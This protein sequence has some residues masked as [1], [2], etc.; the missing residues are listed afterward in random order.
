MALAEVR[1]PGCGVLDI[2]DATV[3]YSGSTDNNSINQRSTTEILLG[4]LRTAWKENKNFTPINR[5]MMKMRLKIGKIWL[6][7]I[8]VYAPTDVTDPS[9]SEEFYHQLSH[10]LK[11][12]NNKDL[13]LML[14]DFNA[15]IGPAVKPTRLHGVHNPDTRN[16][17][18]E[19]FLE[20]CTS[21]G[22]VLTNTL[23]PH[24]KI[25]QEDMCWITS[26]S[27]KSLEPLY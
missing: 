19:R 12:V 20:F 6:S 27:I 11:G 26:W 18:G 15:R 4:N 17:N 3:A 13:L 8:S 24:K 1:W 16:N 25:H 2:E 5:R 22:L 10:I 9:I 21:H 14:R 23:F 7:I